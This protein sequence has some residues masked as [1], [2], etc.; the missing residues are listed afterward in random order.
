MGIVRNKVKNVE[1]IDHLVNRLLGELRSLPV[2]LITI[3]FQSKLSDFNLEAL[4]EVEDRC[5]LQIIEDSDLTRLLSE[6]LQPGA[7]VYNG[8]CR[9]YPAGFIRSSDPDTL[10]VRYLQNSGGIE[11]L[12]SDVWANADVT[13]YREQRVLKSVRAKAEI[14]QFFEARALVKLKDGQA[15]ATI[16]QELSFPGVP[17]TWIYSVGDEV[18]G[19]WDASDGLFIPNSSALTVQDVVDKVGLN[20]ITLGLVTEVGRQTGKIKLLPNLELPITRDEISHNDRDLVA[21]LLD[22]GD[23]VPVRLYRHPEGSIRLR[24]DDIDDD[25]VLYPAMSLAVGGEPW[26]REDRDIPAASGFESIP[27]EPDE[28]FVPIEL[29]LE[30]DPS[31]T[32]APERPSPSAV[33]ASSGAGQGKP[34]T[35]VDKNKESMA[36][37]EAKQYREKLNEA[38][39]TIERLTTEKNLKHRL[40][41]EAEASLDALRRQAKTDSRSAKK[42]KLA[43]GRVSSNTLSRRERFD[44]DIDW[45]NEELR[46]VWIGRYL[47]NDR[48][49]YVLN[50]STFTYG[51]E[52]FSSLKADAKDEEVIRKTVRVVLDIVTGREYDDHKYEIH[53]LREGDKVGSDPVKRSDGAKAQRAYI[54]QKT[55][56]A[57]RLHFWSLGNN[58]VEFSRVVRHDD[59]KP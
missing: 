50:L 8:A 17:L 55:S 59:F 46:R 24:M 58:R 42:I 4:D 53:D 33:W 13:E 29:T 5:D 30:S 38:N 15:L 40:W 14:K 31:P 51:P 2:V 37:W 11:K 6:K 16:R 44:S 7:A 52:F 22:E 9:V 48:K 19:V 57:R 41:I 18:E 39:Q 28:V 23:V 21:D 35:P 45:F 1:G 10:P 34:S 32:L 27:E 3:P 56:A 36:L 47:P 26:L 49:T 20:N 25:E 54:E 43:S 12:V